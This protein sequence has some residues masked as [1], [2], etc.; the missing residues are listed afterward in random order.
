MKQKRYSIL[1]VFL[2]ALSVISQLVANIGAFKQTAFLSWSV[3]GGTIVFIVTYVI[4]DI[5]SEVYGYKASRFTCWLSFTMNL[6]AVLMLQIAIW[7]PAPQ[8]FQ[9]SDEFALVLGQAPRMVL[10][11]QAAYVFGDW[12]N[13]IVFQQLRNRHGQ[14]NK[15]ALRAI[16]SSACGELIDSTIF[17]II[18]FWGINPIHTMPGT[19]LTLVV[20]KTAYEAA[21]LPLTVWCCRKVQAFENAVK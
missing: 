13:D 20:L 12:M 4:S 6:F 16:L 11:G 21:V 3:P 9:F 7:L 15:F 5:F 1:F 19:I 8:W 10:A 14:G 18:A 2:V 17:T